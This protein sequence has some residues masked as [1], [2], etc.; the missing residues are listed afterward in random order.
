MSKELLSI[1]FR[2]SNIPDS[3]GSTY[4]NKLITIG[5]YDTLEEAV[6]I[7]NKLLTEVLS[8]YFQVR[9]NDRFSVNGF[10]GSPE[11]LVSNCCYPT[12]GVTYFAKITKL[13][14]D[15]LEDT[16]NNIFD[17]TDKYIEYHNKMDD[18]DEED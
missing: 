17:S 5:I 13:D 16:I 7:G 1:E 10:L 18:N 9:K 3:I 6:K 14:F 12:K 15:N 2:Y 8:K 4:R 11:R